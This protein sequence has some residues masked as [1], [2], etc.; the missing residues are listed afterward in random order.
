M[1]HSDLVELGWTDEQWNRI[2]SVVAEEAQK[3]RVAA[4]IL[5]LVG[6]EDPITVAVAPYTLTTRPNPN[7]LSARLPQERLTVNSDPT[8]YLTKIAVNV[9]LRTREAADPSL[10]AALGMFRRAANY[11][12][13]TEDALIFN[14]RPGPHQ[15][16]P[17]GSTGIPDV[18]QMTGD[19]A[20][21]GLLS[22]VGPWGNRTLIDVEAALT[23]SAA[24]GDKVVTAIIQAIN[25]LD[26]AGQLGPY[27]CV[28]SPYLFEA[29]CTPN[30]NLVLPR[31]RILPFLEGPL[32]R[33]SAIF[34]GP[35]GSSPPTT[36]WGIVIATS[37][38]P[39]EL[40]VASE[41]KIRYLQTTE[42]PR[43]I[44]RVSERIAVRIKEPKAIALL[45][46]DKPAEERPAKGGTR[47]KGGTPAKDEKYQAD[48]KSASE[49]SQ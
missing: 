7:G 24:T 28:L 19:S 1:M 43:L 22:F 44:F 15:L 31:D 30:G 36:A 34:Q 40:I 2:S 38:N 16:P 48:E 35:Y 13:R 42:E 46:W 47:A 8:L 10:T 25:K 49:A 33:S 20:V 5:P 14:G 12:A 37:G 3:A 26:T 4:Q 41:I 39:I 45:Q 32:L 29:I 17:F 6:P 27:A 21:D 11:I 9:P 18:V 23:K